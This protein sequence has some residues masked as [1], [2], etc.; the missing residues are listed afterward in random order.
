LA[1]D[2]ND[3]AWRTQA[4]FGIIGAPQS[5]GLLVRLYL[6]GEGTMAV[7]KCQHCGQSVMSIEPANVRTGHV[8]S[9]GMPREWVMYEGGEELHRCQPHDPSL[10]RMEHELPAA[11]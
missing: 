10:A 8:S 9:S 1:G 3:S 5:A 2:F 4:A 11:G 6:F 7:I